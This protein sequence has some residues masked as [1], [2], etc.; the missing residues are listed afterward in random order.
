[1]PTRKKID[2]LPQEIK[3]E[4]VRLFDSGKTYAEIAQWLREMNIDVSHTSVWRW[5]K[6]IVAAWERAREIREQVSALVGE[7]GKNPST[8]LTEVAIDLFST[9]IL[10]ALRDGI[11]F[12]NSDPIQLGRLA[13][14]LQRTEIAR[15]KLRLDFDKRAQIALERIEDSAKKQGL[16][17]ETI[18]TIREE[19]YGLAPN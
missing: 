6:D 5:K 17:A 18:K 7:L 3:D 11:D 9:G 15:N 4:I 19:I 8:E 16:T 2:R 12:S 1:M 14:Y 13:G 10:D